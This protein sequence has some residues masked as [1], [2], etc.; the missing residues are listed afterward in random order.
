M[1]I[2]WKILNDNWWLSQEIVENA[3][4]SFPTITNLKRTWKAIPE[5]KFKIYAYLLKNN[6]IRLWQ[7]T[8][9]ELFEVIKEENE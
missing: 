6:Y 3:N 1:S 4:I 2:F 7:Y 8:L 5:I 9:P